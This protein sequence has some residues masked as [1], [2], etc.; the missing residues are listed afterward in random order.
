MRRFCSEKRAFS[1]LMCW[2]NARLIESI[3]GKRRK[4]DSS[5]LSMMS[6]K[7]ATLSPMRIGELIILLSVESGI[8]LPDWKTEAGASRISGSPLPIRFITASF[9]A[10]LLSF[11]NWAGVRPSLATRFRTFSPAGI[12]K[13]ATASTAVRFKITFVAAARADLVCLGSVNAASSDPINLTPSFFIYYN[14]V[15]R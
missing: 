10:R 13:M 3:I 1:V 12:V 15:G 7:P 8:G 2:A 4:R 9:E 11:R 6:S 14:F 5:L